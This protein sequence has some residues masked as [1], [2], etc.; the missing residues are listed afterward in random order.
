MFKLH[1]ELVNRKQVVIHFLHL[2]LYHRR[3][4][5]ILRQ[6][7]RKIQEKKIS[8]VV[9]TFEYTMENRAFAPRSKCSIFHNIFKYK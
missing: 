8:K 7:Q 2:F 9:N 1:Q 5:S 4:F 3:S 6:R